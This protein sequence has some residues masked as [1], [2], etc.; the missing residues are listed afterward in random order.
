[1]QDFLALLQSPE[2][3]KAITNI[4]AVLAALGIGIEFTPFIKFNPISWAMKKLGK[5]LNHET[6][7]AMKDLRKKMDALDK[8]FTQKQIDDLRWNILDFASSCRNHHK[9]T[10]EEFNH[11][12]D[13]HKKYEKILEAHGMQNGQIDEDFKYI[14]EIYNECMHEDSFL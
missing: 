4:L 7:E 12:L 10:K 13:A 6:L 2:L 9:H 11:V 5:A 3:S 14:Q 1:M 8:D